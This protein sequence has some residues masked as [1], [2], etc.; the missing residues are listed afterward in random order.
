MCPVSPNRRQGLTG[1]FTVHP[2]RPEPDRSQGGEHL[3]GPTCCRWETVGVWKGTDDGEGKNP[4][5]TPGSAG[6]LTTDGDLMARNTP[7]ATLI[8]TGIE[9]LRTSNPGKDGRVSPER[10]FSGEDVRIMH[11]VLDTEMTEH[12]AP[13]PIVVQVLEGN[14]R[15]DVEGE[16]HEMGV[17]G[18]VH[19]AAG[20]LHAVTPVGG[21]ARILIHLLTPV[22]RGPG[23]YG[24]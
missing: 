2:P 8:S 3:E 18:M 11:L 24:Q 13:S 6:H 14:V 4:S 9:Q 21:P 12:R 7:P 1:L 17:G 15:F 16:N 19:V 22:H 20:I 10:L 23:E 5:A